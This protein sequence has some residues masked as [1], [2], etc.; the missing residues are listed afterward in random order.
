[1]FFFFLTLFV[2]THK[3]FTFGIKETL[4][5]NG[6][7]FEKALFGVFSRPR[8]FGEPRPMFAFSGQFFRNALSLH[9][10]SPN[11]KHFLRFILFFYI[12][13]FNIFESNY[14]GGLGARFA[15]RLMIRS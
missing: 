7:G 2:C 9:S 15:E 14:G 6:D 10:Y 8:A 11:W 4:F 3:I 12:I 5:A 1:M 13:L